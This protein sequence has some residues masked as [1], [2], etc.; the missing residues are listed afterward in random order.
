MSMD[1]CY[2]TEEKYVGSLVNLSNSNCNRFRNFV[3]DVL[4]DNIAQ[5]Q[6]IVDSQLHTDTGE[7]DYDAWRAQVAQEEQDELT[8]AK[9]LYV[10]W[11]TDKA[12]VSEVCSIMTLVM[13]DPNVAQYK[14]YVF[15]ILSQGVKVLA[16]G[17]AEAYWA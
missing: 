8:E 9:D 4:Q 10:S 7:A 11:S 14:G 5:C 3:A 6:E 16:D 1:L 12:K 13:F 2:I 17:N 15:R